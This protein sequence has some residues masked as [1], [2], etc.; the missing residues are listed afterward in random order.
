MEGMNGFTDC[1]AKRRCDLGVI[2]GSTVLLVLRMV[3]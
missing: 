3:G 2:H 1:K